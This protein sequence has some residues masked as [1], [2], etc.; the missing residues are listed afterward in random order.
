MAGAAVQGRDRYRRGTDAR[1]AVDGFDEVGGRSVVPDEDALAILRSRGTY[2]RRAIQ[3]RLR[4]GR[5]RGDCL[6]YGEEVSRLLAALIALAPVV[7][8]CGDAEYELFVDL[9]TDIA[10]GTGFDNTVVELRDPRGR[11]GS[12]VRSTRTAAISSHDYATGHRVAELVGLTAG[13][14]TL[15]VELELDS[16]PVV[17]V[18][19]PITISADRAETVFVTR[20]CIGRTCPM[21]GDDPEAVGCLQGRCVDPE[22]LLGRGADCGSPS[23]GGPPD[24]ST[25][26]ASDGSTVVDSGVSDG[27]AVDG[28]TCFA[29]GHFTPGT[30]LCTSTRDRAAVGRTD[31]GPMMDQTLIELSFACVESCLLADETCYAPCIQGATDSALS[32]ECSSCYASFTLCAVSYCPFECLGGIVGTECFACLGG[33]NECRFDCSE[34]LDRCSGIP[35]GP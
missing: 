5:L 28:A 9:R 1:L 12:I 31:Y 6:R 23:D 14:Y 15:R 21:P 10:G 25:P 13:D 3:R 26:D 7:T 30:D 16:A 4:G 19:V 8:G 34:E 11:L 29:P 35:S 17:D 24:A 20:A 32:D 27:G 33:A 18:I 22:C 2:K